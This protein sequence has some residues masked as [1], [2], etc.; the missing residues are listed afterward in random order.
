MARWD[1]PEIGF[2]DTTTAMIL[3]HVEKM[4]SRL[5]GIDVIQ[6]DRD[7]NTVLKGEI[8]EHYIT[9]CAGLY[10]RL[11]TNGTPVDDIRKQLALAAAFKS[12]ANITYQL[13]QY[14]F[15]HPDVNGQTYAGKLDYLRLLSDQRSIPT[16][17][18]YPSS[19][20]AAVTPDPI[21]AE[22]RK[23]LAELR[24]ELKDLKFPK[25]PTLCRECTKK[26]KTQL[27][28]ECTKHNLRKFP[29]PVSTSVP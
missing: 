21:A 13:C 22:L 15:A 27:F 7:L 11:E 26:G 16:G 14:E 3:T 1:D 20:A 6:M 23:E 12:D 19:V 4:Y 2:R 28:T 18:L 24:K 17:H 5:R 25:S 9:R 29:Q 8:F 10:R